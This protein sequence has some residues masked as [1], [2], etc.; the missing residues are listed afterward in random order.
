MDLPAGLTPEMMDNL[1]RFF[2]QPNQAAY[3]RPSGLLQPN[4]MRG[5]NPRYQY[6]YR[7][8]P[9][10]LTPPRIQVRDANHERDL[11]VQWGTP[12]PWNNDDDG[13]DLIREYYTTQEYPKMVTPPQV[14]VQSAADEKS[15][16]A[17]WRAESGEAGDDMQAGYPKWLF[18]AEKPAEFVNG[19]DEETALGQGWYTTPAEAMS[20]ARPKTPAVPG[21]RR[22]VVPQHQSGPIKY[23]PEEE[24]ER[25]DLMARAA[26]HKVQYHVQWGTPRLRREVEEAEAKARE[27]A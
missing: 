1:A 19:R 26:K 15:K 25:I 17:A 8:Y 23:S 6:K 11:R 13:R 10:A 27:P 16:L 21:D 22:V 5:Y 4:Q 24:A 2:S 7:E 20:A 14:I 12:L 18:H 3:V 9:K